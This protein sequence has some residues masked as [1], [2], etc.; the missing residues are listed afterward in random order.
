MCDAELYKH[1][2]QIIEHVAGMYK[3]V[4]EIHEHAAEIYNRKIFLKQYQHF[5]EKQGLVAKSCKHIPEN[6]QMY[7]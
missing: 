2:V 7:Y 5:A 1:I 6:T 4:A 3:L